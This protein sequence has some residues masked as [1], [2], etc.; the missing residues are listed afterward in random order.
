M[1]PQKKEF[2]SENLEGNQDS[3][4]I[5]DEYGDFDEYDFNEY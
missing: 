2:I 3:D 4:E 1:K 5:D